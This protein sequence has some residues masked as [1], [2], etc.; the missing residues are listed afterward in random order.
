MLLH[1]GVLC[2]GGEHPEGPA[3][4]LPPL[5]QAE[6]FWGSRLQVRAENHGE[7]TMLRCQTSE[8]RLGP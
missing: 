6:P 8:G 3:T 2:L 7:L 1:F 5:S 4:L